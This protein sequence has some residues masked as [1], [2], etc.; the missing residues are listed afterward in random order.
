MSARGGTSLR[1]NCRDEVPRK[2][3]YSS[4]LR[5][6]VCIMLLTVTKEGGS[7]WAPQDPPEY[8]S[9]V[10]KLKLRAATIKHAAANKISL[11]KKE[12]TLEEDIL[13]LERR[14]DEEI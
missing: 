13:I 12:H 2:I 4:S 8:A 1:N 10:I 11:K 9:C 3:N 7:S 14:L 6:M 5:D